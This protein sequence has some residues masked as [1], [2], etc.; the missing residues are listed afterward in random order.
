MFTSSRAFQSSVVDHDD[1]VVRILFMS[2]LV[3]LNL[4]VMVT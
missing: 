1:N 3:S 4:S 2:R